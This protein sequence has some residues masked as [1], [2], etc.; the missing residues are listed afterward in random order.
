MQR[1]THAQRAACLPHL[2]HVARREHAHTLQGSIAKRLRCVTGVLGWS[3]CRWTIPLPAS[4]CR[5]TIPLPAS[6]CRVCMCSLLV[7]SYVHL[8][9]P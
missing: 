4:F 8:A 7:S 3:G 9:I 1:A 2:L 5:W 6:F